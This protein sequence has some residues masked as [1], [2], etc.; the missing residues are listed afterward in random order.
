[1]Q[2]RGASVSALSQVREG[3]RRVSVNRPVFHHLAVYLR[4]IGRIPLGI[5]M[6]GTGNPR[7]F[8]SEIE[9]PR[10]IRSF[11]RRKTTFFWKILGAALVSPSQFFFLPF[12]RHF[13]PLFRLFFVLFFIILY[14]FS[15][16][17]TFFHNFHNFVHSE[18]F[19][20]ISTFSIWFFDLLCPEAIIY[21]SD[22]LRSH[23]FCEAI[24]YCSDLLCPEAI[25]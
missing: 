10:G 22:L 18:T 15:Q 16:F 13:S 11:P 20:Y 9:L 21:C 4:V 7:V 8:G 5:S 23:H 17:C 25:I 3:E 14:F 2:G 24:I 1:M 6:I 12:F 19:V